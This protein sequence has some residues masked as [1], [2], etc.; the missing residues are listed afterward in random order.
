MKHTCSHTVPS[1]IGAHTVAPGHV[2]V[3][4]LV[5]HCCVVLLAVLSQVIDVRT[6]GS[7]SSTSQGV[8]TIEWPECHLA[9]ATA[10]GTIV[11]AG[12][13]RGVRAWDVRTSSSNSGDGGRRNGS[14]SGVSTELLSSR[15]PDGEPVSLLHVDRVELV[16]ATSTSALHSPAS[17]AVW[18]LPCGQRVQLLSST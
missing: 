5:L 3:Q 11:A 16:A 14:G 13:C 8:I 12:G 17:I 7:G 15:M 2:T 1:L 9:A 6:P 4:A 18:S 10:Y